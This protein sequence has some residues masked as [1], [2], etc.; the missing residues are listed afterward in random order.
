MEAMTLSEAKEIC[1]TWREIE[2]DEAIDFEKV[3]R[4]IGFIRGHQ[5][6]WDARGKEVALLRSQIKELMG[7]TEPYTDENYGIANSK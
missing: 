2:D 4:A 7:E 1:K 3:N 6:G 5:A